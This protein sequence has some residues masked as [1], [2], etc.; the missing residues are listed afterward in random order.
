MSE[1]EK[2]QWIAKDLWKKFNFLKDE[3]RL[4]VAAVFL[5]GSQNYKLDICIDD[6]KSDIDAK[7]IVVP[8]L[9]DLIKGGKPLSKEYVMDDGSH[10]EAKD[11]RL[12]PLLWAKANPSYLEILFTNYRVGVNRD[13]L[14]LLEMKNDIARMA[15]TRMLLA[16]MG[17]INSEYKYMLKSTP[18]TKE[19]FEKYGYDPKSYSHLL[20]LFY[21]FEEVLLHGRNLGDVLVLKKEQRKILL[22]AKKGLVAFD[23]A[24][25]N[26]DE[27]MSKVE[28]YKDVVMKRPKCLNEETYERVNNIVHN[29]IYESCE[30][31]ILESNGL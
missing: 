7:A 13:I 1:L 5:Q 15:R 3:K 20:R 29:I 14:E 19:N 18:S 11:I 2:N 28:K 8:T 23:D 17:T 12:Y 31:E 30:M 10:V 25:Q 22:E 4:N 21:M 9:E 6:Y 24:K 26:A 27:I 16:M